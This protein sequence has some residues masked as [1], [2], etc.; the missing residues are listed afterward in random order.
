VANILHHK[1]RS[2]LSAF[3]IGIGVCMLIALSGLSRGS[4]SEVADRWE[5]VRADLIVYPHGLGENITT[6]SGF[7]VSDKLAPRIRS[8]YGDIVERVVPIIIWQIKVGGQDQA[9]VGVDPQDWDT[10]TGARAPI[11][12]RIFDPRNTFGNWIAELFR[13][14]TE[15]DTPIDLTQADLTAPD[16]DGLEM[17][18]DSRLARAGKYSLGQTIHVA[19]FD[20]TVVGIVPA[21]GMSRVYLPRRTAQHLS[22]MGLAR[23]TLM[24]VKLKA[25]VDADAAAARLRHVGADVVPLRQYRGMLEHKFGVMFVYVDAVN[26]IALVI[27]FLFIM[28]TL[29]TMVLQRTREIAILKSCGATGAFILRQILAESMLLTAA[30]VA[31]GVA[32]SFLTAWLIQRLAPLLTVT[33][34][35]QWIAVAAGA[36]ALGGIVS[37]IYPAWR[38]TRVDMVEALTLE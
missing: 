23:S 10:V 38:A 34:T 30:G 31:A 33:I 20:W 21:G 18:I 27:A 17:V 28:T 14:P 29:Y 37:A 24:F 9:A 26:V 11:E 19:N 15:D 8:E 3:G 22:G 32:L 6:L 4:L 2:A 16:H 1:L 35:W 25:G 13:K 36:A 5:T 12:G 7:G